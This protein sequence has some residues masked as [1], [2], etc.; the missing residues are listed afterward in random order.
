MP[1]RSMKTKNFYY[2]NVSLRGGV[3]LHKLGKKKIIIIGFDEEN[4]S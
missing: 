1:R 3:K 4:V 2:K